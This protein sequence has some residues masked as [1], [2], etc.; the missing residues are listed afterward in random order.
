MKKKIVAGILV[1][2]MVTS[3]GVTGCGKNQK[4]PETQ[5]TQ[6]TVEVS[7][8]FAAMELLNSQSTNIIDDNYRNFYE[9]FPYSFRDSNGD[10]IGD[11][12]GID[13]SID[14]L[15]SLGV[16]AVWMTPIFA[17]PSY[18]KYDATD[19]CAIDPQFG[20]MADFETLLKDFHDAGI[21]LILDLA[22]NHTSN[23]H[24][25]FKTATDYLRSLPAGKEPS[26]DE[27]PYV[28]Y[29]NF[30]KES[31]AGFEK[32]A[33]TD[34]YYECR[35][36]SGMPDL[37]LDSPVV[38]DEITKI[39]KFW[40]DKGVDGF[41]LD[42]VTSYYTGSADRNVEF[43]SWINET[44]KAEKADAYLL[45]ECWE[46]RSTYSRYY[47][48]GIDSFFNY[49]F[50]T[51]S[52]TIVTAVRTKDALSYAKDIVSVNNMISSHTDKYIDAAFTGGHDNAR[53]AGYFA[54]DLAENSTKVA[55]ALAMLTGGNY[56]LYYGDELGMKGTGDDEN[57]RLPM[58]WSTN[59]G[60]A[61]MCKSLATRDIAMKYG[62]FEEQEMDK[63]SIY[64][65]VK[66][67][68]KLRNIFPEIARGTT[69]VLEDVSS[70]VAVM[71]KEYNGSEIVIVINLS[72]EEKSVDL[73][74]VTVNG[75]SEGD[76]QPCG[77]LLVDKNV[78]KVEGSTLVLPPYAIEI[79]K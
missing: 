49:D 17:A 42:A 10:G 29:Y 61:G 8:A 68:L 78:V 31:S 46:S 67:G 15:T 56:I 20:T 24:E 55:Q 54:G 22:V 77:T 18:H 71:K 35:F 7:N 75:K 40:M 57:K 60:A 5:V 37:N 53:T 64:F 11:L 47:E 52:G 50:A 65:Y 59:A 13:S 32:V 41:R 4:K 36:Y 79:L 30:K 12:Q 14:Y 69:T 73:S 27:C 38:K 9:I 58:Q 6:Q 25:W 45:G 33:G 66:E 21:N 23:Q 1:L 3:L 51:E 76:L 48:R 62:S 26:A 34:Y 44:V 72:D 16:N 39:I 70:E 63:N 28:E 74:S 43:L 2:T 19:Y